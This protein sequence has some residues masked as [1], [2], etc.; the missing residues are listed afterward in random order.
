VNWS[1]VLGGGVIFLP[2]IP[3][4]NR[5]RHPIGRTARM[6]A[7]EGGRLVGQIRRSGPGCGLGARCTAPPSRPG[8]GMGHFRPAP[9]FS[10]KFLF[11][12]LNSNRERELNL[13]IVLSFSSA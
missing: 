10:R 11:P 1:R 8:R 9:V 2:L 12:P 4:G 3:P 13:G 6:Q 5:R 7:G